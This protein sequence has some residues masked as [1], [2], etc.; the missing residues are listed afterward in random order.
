MNVFE[1]FLPA[2]T[3]IELAFFFLHSDGRKYTKALISGRG[4]QIFFGGTPPPRIELET[5][6]LRYPSSCAV[7]AQSTMVETKDGAI[8]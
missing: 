1:C 6:R 7:S 3:K 4:K 2:P 5:I 8:F